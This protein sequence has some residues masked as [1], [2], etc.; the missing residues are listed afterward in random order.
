MMRWDCEL[1]RGLDSFLKLDLLRYLVAAGGKPVAPAQVAEDIG[2]NVT[3]VTN[4]FRGFVALGIVATCW[5]DGAPRFVLAAP[6]PARRAID[7]LLSS[8]AGLRR[9][10]P[11]PEGDGPPKE[12]A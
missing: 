5:R 2:H 12:A 7:R 6:P 3:D 10:W 1:V 4:A 9:T 8:W 11:A